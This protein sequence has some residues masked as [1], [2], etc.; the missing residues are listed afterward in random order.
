MNTGRLLA[1]H[2]YDK[3]DMFVLSTI[4]GTG[5]V[6]VRCR[7]DTPFR[8]PTMID[9]YNLYKGGIDELDQLLSTYQKIKE[10]VEKSFLSF[11]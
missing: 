4:H 3:R 1:L 6:E 5:N 7:D 10:V 11:T 8:K 9:D 2:W